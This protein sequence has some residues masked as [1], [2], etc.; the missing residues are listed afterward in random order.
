[1]MEKRMRRLSGILGPV[2]TPFDA[3]S[4]ST[5][6]AALRENIAAHLHH[7]LSG[8]LV[9]GSSGEAP[10]LNEWERDAMVATARDVVPDRKWLIVGVGAE[11]TALAIDRAKR[12]GKAGADLVLCY[13]PHYYATQM[14]R[15]ALAT[16]YRAL[17]DASPVP[18]M[19]YN[20]PK[21]THLV[22]DP[23][24]VH[25]LATHG[26]I[27][28]MKD[29]AGE[30]GN[31]ARYLEAQG[32]GFSVLTGNGVTFA[33]ALALG[34]RGAI[35]AVSLFAPALTLMIADAHAADD[36]AE[37][38]AMQERLV[39]LAKEVAGAMGPA[40]I[41]AAMDAVGMKGGPVRPPLMQLDAA[42][43]ARVEALLRDARIPVTA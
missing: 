34:V 19:L 29:S 9:G 10:L 12:A 3:A 31:L 16:H 28:G 6:T 11:S 2:T 25:E 38:A 23:D 4:G 36:R 39:P 26:N 21:F 22:L 13:P 20:I 24:L 35:L 5:D 40:G 30:L 27:A 8:V 41:K 18:V 1:M 17:A 14:T 32:D 43:R 7:G 42:Q 33:Q 37:A 15:A